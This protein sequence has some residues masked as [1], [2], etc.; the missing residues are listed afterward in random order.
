MFGKLEAHQEKATAH[1][2]EDRCVASFFG[3][4]LF[5]SISLTVKELERK[6][7]CYQP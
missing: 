7:G 5:E 3:V 1:A 4:V 6:E 2:K